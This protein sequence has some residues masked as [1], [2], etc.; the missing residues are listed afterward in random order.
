MV[1]IFWSSREKLR[2]L[3]RIDVFLCFLGNKYITV[4]IVKKCKEIEYMLLK[5]H[6]IFK[7]W[8]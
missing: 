4:I 6:G 5:Y 2:I 7:V 1:R 3:Y 8:Q